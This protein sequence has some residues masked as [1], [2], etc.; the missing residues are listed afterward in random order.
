M[1]SE[2]GTPEDRRWLVEPLGSQEVNF[3]ITAGDQVEVTAEV[4]EA[5][6]HL[7]Q[8]LRG[9]DVQGYIYDPKC[10]QRSI[11]CTSNGKCT[12][13]FQHPHCLIDYHC[14]LSRIG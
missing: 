6:T 5:F 2:S 8:T 3:Q 7:I 4:Q 12:S 9:D 10:T 14:S 13:E 1:T 11:D